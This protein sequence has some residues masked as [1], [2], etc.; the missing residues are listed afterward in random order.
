MAKNTR[1]SQ[2]PTQAALSAIEEALHMGGDTT[3]NEAAAD[4]PAPPDDPRRNPRESG[5]V[6]MPPVAGPYSE[7][8]PSIRRRATAGRRAAQA[9]ANDDRQSVGQILSALHARPPLT[10][11]YIAAIASAWWVVMALLIGY[12]R[13]YQEISQADGLFGLIDLPYFWLFFATLVLPPVMFFTIAAT[14]RRAQEMR[15]VSRAMTE[16]T[17]RLAEPEGISTDAVVSVSQAIRREVAALGDGI[18]RAIAR[19][20]ELETMVRSEV[21]TLE[22][23][24][25]ENEL[26]V[27]ALVDELQSERDAIVAHGTRLRESI[28]GAHESFSVDVEGVA[29]RID[30]TLAEATDRINASLTESSKRLTDGFMTQAETARAQAAEAAESVLDSFAARGDEI[31]Q[32]FGQINASLTESSK[33]LTDGFM[34]QA[35]T[36]RT[37]A[38]EAAESVLNSF[39]ARGDEITQRF[40]Q[41]NASLTDSSTRLANGFM[42]QAETARA[43]ANEAAESILESFTSHGREITQRFGQ[44][45]IELSEQLGQVGIEVANALDSRTARLTES[46]NNSMEKLV[47]TI[48]SNGNEVHDMLTVRLAESEEAIGRHGNEVADRIAADTAALSQRVSENV[49]AFEANLKTHG[50]AL[51]EQISQAVDYLSDQARDALS[52]LDERTAGK[53]R[54]T[55]EAID[56][57]IQRIEQTIDGRTQ[58]LNETLAGRTLELARTIADGSKVAAESVDKTVAGMG[59]YFA[60]KAQEIAIT[61]SDRAEEID[62]TLGKRALE[63]T[64]N[65]DSRIQR[66][67]DQVSNKLVGITG[68]IE[69]RGIAL[70]DSLVSKLDTASGSII[71]KLDQATDSLIIK[72]DNASSSLVSKLDDS[73]N[74]LVTRLGETSGA[75]AGKLDDSAESIVNKV[76][77]V[78]KHLRQEAVEVELTLNQLG[79]QMTQTLVERTGETV[80]GF[81]EQTQQ[82]AATH[83]ALRENVVGSLDKLLES[84]RLFKQLLQ[85]V[86]ESLEPLENA[87]AKRVGALQTALENTVGNTRSSVDW[88]D[89]QMNELRNI[90]GGVLRDL[91]AVTQR[92]EGQGRYIASVA[93]TL[94]ETHGRIDQ[95]LEERR[96]AIEHIIRLLVERTATI[97][98]NFGDRSQQIGE[99]LA[100]FNGL[101][102]DSLTAAESRA[103]EIARHIIDSTN[104]IS[105]TI[106]KQHEI[107]RAGY[108]EERG[109]TATALKTTYEEAM[110]EMKQ[111]FTDLQERFSETA[112]E[113]RDVASEVQTSL[114]QTRVELKRGVLELPHE[115]RES[116]DAMRRVVAD[117]LKAL[118]ELNE[119]VSR[120]AREMETAEPTHAY[121]ENAAVTGGRRY[122]EAGSVS[123]LPS[124]RQRI[125]APRGEPIEF[126]RTGPESAKPAR[127]GPRAVP[128]ARNDHEEN[129]R[130]GWLTELITTAEEARTEEPQQ[131]IE[132][133]DSLSLDIARMIDHDAAVELW[134]RHRRGERNIFTRRLYTPQ[135]QKTFDEIRNRYRKSNDFRETVDRYIDEFERL[136]EQVSRDDRGQVLSKTYLTSDTGKV[137][138]LLAHAAARL[139]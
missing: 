24:Y 135:G 53:L 95:S 54:E 46:M 34:T 74:S 42:L 86:T 96:E 84:N 108:S 90:S 67:E 121:R 126:R 43:Q 105:Q 10:A 109:R 7:E 127:K 97:E 47:D 50:P 117:Q 51:A 72:F 2:D 94:S 13:S 26:R 102:Q 124:P 61:I 4:S 134:D 55:T 25:D 136:L 115:T 101:L 18:E 21:A 123:E 32:R 77:E 88:I 45:G 107:I 20:S 111:M 36:A 76:S 110:D 39:A 93:E 69:T 103:E 11:I 52:S 30:N 29:I 131:T 130:S 41:I 31:T 114:D 81:A 85:G 75:L 63:M 60:S 62:Q 71:G 133:L 89:N 5:P 106:N 56:S 119:I 99:R 91:A 120:H 33:R 80:R 14:V 112:R 82:I 35:E 1:K 17:L 129:E 58:H 104:Q 3:A 48:V 19:A 12:S 98:E 65:L 79:N 92:F 87:M 139:N 116:A 73:S 27:R 83:E 59:E 44:I 100:A 9:P 22:R 137:Y 128:S 57:R 15:L 118:A 70:A 16:V 68:S 125:A 132:S 37:Q 66:F 64:E 113:V 40:G 23:A 49:Q 6:T 8:P 28:G 78:S 38:A 138:T 122:A